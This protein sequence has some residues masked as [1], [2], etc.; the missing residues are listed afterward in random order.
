MAIPKFK[1]ILVPL[2]KLAEN[3]EEV[4]LQEAVEKLATHFNLTEEEKNQRI[5]L[6]DRQTI[7]YNRVGWAKSDL[8]LSF[9]AE[10]TRRG[11]FK[12]TDAGLNILKSNPKRIDRA[13]LARNG[14][15]NSSNENEESENIADAISYSLSETGQMLRENIIKI[16]NKS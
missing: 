13:F 14:G 10:Y 8:K 16:Y 6:T 5:N 1:D 3:G 15:I 7:F 9:L 11:C 2:L 4:C 12:I